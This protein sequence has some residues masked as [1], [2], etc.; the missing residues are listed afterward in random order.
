MITNNET[1]EQEEPKTKP[2]PKKP[3]PR[4]RPARREEPAEAIA[5]ANPASMVDNLPNDAIKKAVEW[6]DF[7]ALRIAKS[8]E[9]PL[10]VMIY[11]KINEYHNKT[12]PKKVELQKHGRITF[13]HFL[14]KKFGENKKYK[15]GALDGK[16]IFQVNN[17]EG[18][19]TKLASKSYP[20]LCISCASV[21]EVIFDKY[22]LKQSSNSVYFKIKDLGND[23]YLIDEIIK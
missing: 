10:H 9:E 16:I 6:I 21:V 19:G 14:T 7:D 8:K 12:E 11:Y 20:K 15:F 18:F 22:K 5:P 23:F 3:T 2:K 1:L 13:S 4:T 17:K